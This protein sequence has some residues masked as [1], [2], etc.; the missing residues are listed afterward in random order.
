L[1]E[2][3]IVFFIT[4]ALYFHFEDRGGWMSKGWIWALIAVVATVA[5]MFLPCL[6]G[7]IIEAI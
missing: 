5:L 4:I 6:I 7:F 1:I 3:L 2:F